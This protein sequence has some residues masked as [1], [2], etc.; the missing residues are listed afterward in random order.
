M[1]TIRIYFEGDPAGQLQTNMG[2]ASRIIK[3]AAA[4]TAQNARDEIQRQ[5]EEDFTNTGR[6]GQKYA[7]SVQTQVS[8]GGANIRVAVT[9]NKPGLEFLNEGGI[10]RGNPYMWIP[11]SGTGIRNVDAKDYPGRLFIVKRKS[12]GTPLLM[13]A[14][15]RKPKYAGVAQVTIKKKFHTI[16]I[17]NDVASRLQAMY[18]AQLAALR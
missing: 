17:V 8:Q 6:L 12:G 16:D 1:P 10:V 18:E 15:D 3:Q 9:S 2:K 4:L 11:L 5:V 13:D 7:G 14:A